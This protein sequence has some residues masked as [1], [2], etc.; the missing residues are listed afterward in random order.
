[1]LEPARRA[2]LACGWLFGL[3]A[4]L[5]CSAC[6]D[7]DVR[8]EHLPLQIELLQGPDTLAVGATDTLR[9]GAMVGYENC[10]LENAALERRG[11]SLVVRG[12]ARC[13]FRSA[14]GPYA[15]FD[16]VT[17]PALPNGQMLEFALP[18]LEAGTYFTIAGDLV[19][20]LVVSSTPVPL[21]ERRVV[22]RGDI[23]L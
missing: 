16:V 15:T 3:P 6:H 19:D 11:D 10:T 4:L 23:I 12:G 14:S 20:T 21:P 1:M 7:D 5:V 22:A 8:V 9:V 2:L 13:E 18:S 17:A